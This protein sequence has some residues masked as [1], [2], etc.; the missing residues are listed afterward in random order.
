MKEQDT[1]DILVPVFNGEHYIKKCLDSLLSQTY[2]NIRIVVA[3]DGSTD[4]TAKILAQ[5]AKNHNNI[6]VCKKENEKSISKTRN[7]LLKQI[8]SN[9]FTFFDSDDYAEP[10]YIE[11]LY[12]LLINYNA[13]M[14]ICGK[15]RHNIKKEVNLTKENGKPKKILFLNKQE[16]L[17]EMISSNLKWNCVCKTNENKHSQK[18]SIWP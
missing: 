3:D 10:T 4:G 16:A 14:S 6:E 13:D 9:Y 8:K 17:A 2:K 15:L 5:Y 18:C 11:T 7:F 1:I 12:H